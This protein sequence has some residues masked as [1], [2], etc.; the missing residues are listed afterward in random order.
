[1]ECGIEPGHSGQITD[2]DFKFELF[3]DLISILKRTPKYS[4]ETFADN[5]GFTLA[6]IENMVKYYRQTPKNKNPID[7]LKERLYAEDEPEYVFKM[8]KHST[9]RIIFKTYNGL[10]EIDYM[11]MNSYKI[12]LQYALRSYGLKGF[13]L[14]Y[15]NHLYR[16]TTIEI[17]NEY[18]KRTN[19]D[20]LGDDIGLIMEWEIFMAGKKYT[21]KDGFWGFY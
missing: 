15:L 14:H 20:R 7:E 11:V 18:L 9:P 6:T 16:N 2:P 13:Y 8:E 19:D 5:K 1:M 21:Q 3:R 12:A 10:F 4:V 17:I